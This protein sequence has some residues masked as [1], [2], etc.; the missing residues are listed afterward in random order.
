M[1]FDWTLP[2][3]M[4]HVHTWSATR[5]CMKENGPGFFERAGRRLAEVW[6][7]SHRTQS[8]SM[9]LQWIVGRHTNP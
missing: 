7:D 4:T 8:V 3:F 2:Q 1:K 5:L 6:G 9:R